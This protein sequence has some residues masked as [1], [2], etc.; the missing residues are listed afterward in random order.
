MMEMMEEDETRSNASRLG[1]RSSSSSRRRQSSYNNNNDE[2]EDEKNGFQSPP[3]AVDEGLDGEQDDSYHPEGSS[4]KAASAKNKGK[5]NTRRQNSRSSSSNLDKSDPNHFRFSARNKT[6]L[7]YNEDE[8]RDEDEDSDAA[9]ESY[10]KPDRS[11]QPIIEKILF[12]REILVE[13]ET[14]GESVPEREFFIK[15][16]YQS[17]LH[18]S[19]KTESEILIL[20]PKFGK[21][22]I[23]RY[24]TMGID[25]YA[26]LNPDK[27][28]NPDFI[29]V[30][31]ILDEVNVKDEISGSVTKRFYVKWQSLP[32]ET[33]TWENAT[34]INDDKK[35][36]LYRKLQREGRYPRKIIPTPDSFTVQGEN[37]QGYSD[38]PVFENGNQL[39]EY[40]L[41][42][43]SWL[44]KNWYSG[45]N[46]ILADEMGLGK[47]VQT[48][49]T[50][51]HL[52][53]KEGIQGPFLVIAPLSTIQHWRREFENWTDLNC[54][55]YHGPTEA[56]KIIRDYEWNWR[57]D[58]LNTPIED[59]EQ[60]EEDEENSNNDSAGTVPG[61]R[62]KYRFEVILTTYEIIKADIGVFK[63]VN[64]WQYVV[65]D[66]A[67]RL[68]NSKGKLLQVLKKDFI[69]EKTDAFNWN[70]ITKQY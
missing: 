8:K 67:H 10:S 54:V 42:G 37:W 52:K 21:S 61:K 46:C 29:Q 36:E 6:R 64:P 48:V 4:S 43:M 9:Y 58:S 62:R 40:Q 23:K 33:S 25:P 41:Q 20:E 7:N 27:P 38:S 53:T 15:W 17:Y 12:H 16:K 18:T 60:Q 24:F 28:F 57:E 56:R 66:E 5:T 22:K 59:S 70:A 34:D 14:T 35:I 2:S 3:T 51:W 31:R 30:D 44:L 69:Y 1:N 13:D 26:E 45:N 55:L 47:T 68:K 39:R 65:M 11:L 49:S 50:L 63:S 32:Y 19:W